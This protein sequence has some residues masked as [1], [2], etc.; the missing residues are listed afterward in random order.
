MNAKQ[1]KKL[2]DNGLWESSRM[3]SPEH[4]AVLAQYVETTK[5][6]SRIEL[7]EQEYERMYCLMN[8]SLR[9]RKQIS[10]KLF[11]PFEMLEVI[12]IV[13]Y[14]DHSQNKFM[15]DGEWFPISDIESALLHS[16]S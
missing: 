12:G 14:I 11:H 6:R 1:S 15:V 7:N 5:R 8:S 16:P 2:I 13:D 9:L 3:M 10:I 4:K